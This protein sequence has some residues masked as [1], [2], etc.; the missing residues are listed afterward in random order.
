ML[1]SRQ[2]P[3]SSDQISTLQGWFADKGAELMRAVV[4]S[5]IADHHIRIADQASKIPLE[6]IQKGAITQGMV[7][8]EIAAAR[9]QIFLEV[10]N[11]LR[12]GRIPPNT[13][14]IDVAGIM[15]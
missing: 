2:N 11:D 9:L 1:T 6:I 13:V 5:K 3:L 12:N 10:W 15:K 8:Q 7:D 4:I 14:D